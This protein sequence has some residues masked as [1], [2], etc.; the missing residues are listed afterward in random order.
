MRPDRGGLR[1]SKPSD[2]AASRERVE[3]SPRARAFLLQ[4]GDLRELR[5]GLP[6]HLRRLVAGTARRTAPSRAMS[7]SW[8]A[9]ALPAAIVRAAFS[10]RHSCHGPR[11][12][13]DLPPSSSSTAVAT[14]SR[15]Q[16]SWATRMTA[17]SSDVSLSSSHS[18]LRTS[19]WFVGSSSSRRSGSPASARPSEARVSSPP[20]NVSSWRSK[21]SSRKPRPRSPDAARSRQSQPPACSSR[22]LCLGVAP[23]R[24]WSWCRRPSPPRARAARPRARSGPQRRTARTRAAS[25][26]CCSGGRWSC[27]AMRVPFAKAISPAVTLVS[28]VS[29]RSSVVFPAPFGPESA[30]TSAALDAERDAVE[31]RGPGV[32]F[33]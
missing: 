24:R 26:R 28:P 32:L 3:L 23:Q 1:K 25:G 5:L 16:R 29:M 27:S 7:T 13:S 8:R 12:K 15:N 10:R 17:A 19:R 14:A 2:F 31:Q 22:A 9:T 21:S 11:K 18:R 33:A 4:P 30:T 20:E 6:R